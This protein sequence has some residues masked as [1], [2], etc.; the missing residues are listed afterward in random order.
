[1]PW[2]QGD[3][4]PNFPGQCKVERM[5][6]HSKVAAK[7]LKGKR[8]RF[9]KLNMTVAGD[10]FEIFE[11][12]RDFANDTSSVFARVHAFSQ[13]ACLVWHT[14]RTQRTNSIL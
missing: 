12:I 10:L 13:Q 1:M 11:F 6:I 5:E 9:G 2:V 14:H 3:E 7:F 8:D 4:W